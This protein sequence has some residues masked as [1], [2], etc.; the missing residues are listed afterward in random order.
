MIK[1]RILICLLTFFLS[2]SSVF[3]QTNN[4]S[5][6]RFLEITPSAKAA[7]LGGNHVG[8]FDANSTLLYLN[9]AYLTPKSSTLVSASFVNYLSDSRIGFANGA[10]DI[11]NIGTLGIG[12]RYAG[13]GELNQL[14][15]DGN[16]LGSFNASDLSLTT[17]L[18]TMLSEKLSAGAGVDLIH[19]SYHIYNSSA[20]TASGGIYYLDEETDFSAGISF[21]NLGDQLDYYD[22]FREEIPFDISAGFSK[23]PENFPF[24]LNLTFRQLN[25]WDMK[26]VG[27]TEEPS[28]FDNAFRHVIFGGEAAFS[29]NFLFRFGYNRLLHEQAKTDQSFDLAGVSVGVGLKVKGLDIDLSR[30]SYSKIGGIVQISVRSQLK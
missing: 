28:F 11:K 10:Y 6:F 18:S 21:R 7:A 8:M 15:E 22:G 29:E 30:S 9:P 3:A 26:V 16:D 25:N 24:Q 2:Y 17:A 1:I 27:E 19:S 23:K 20:I 13:Y 5:I 12:I 4:S 14:D